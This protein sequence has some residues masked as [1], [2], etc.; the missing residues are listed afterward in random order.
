MAPSPDQFRNGSECQQPL[1]GR[2]RDLPL[3]DPDTG[4][5]LVSKPPG[6]WRMP[7]KKSCGLLAPPAF[8]LTRDLAKKDRRSWPLKRR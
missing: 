3:P 1:A 7:D 4:A 5:I 8:L 6:I 2:G